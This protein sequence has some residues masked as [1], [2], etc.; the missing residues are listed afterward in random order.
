MNGDRNKQLQKLRCERVERSFA[1]VCETGRARRTW[2]RGLENNR[3]KVRLV[4]AA[5]NLSLILRKVLGSGK[6]RAFA[7]LRGLLFGPFSDLLLA[8]R[9]LYRSIIASS[10]I[11]R[12]HLCGHRFTLNFTTAA[13]QVPEATLFN[14]LL[15]GR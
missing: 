10:S 7:N 3:K 8:T 12:L 13:I 15:C 1:H 9:R 4:V 14:G 6:P 11:N 2:L 5:H